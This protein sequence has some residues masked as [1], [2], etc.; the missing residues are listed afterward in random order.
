MCN[1]LLLS[2][3]SARAVVLLNIQICWITGQALST[4]WCCFVLG[5]LAICFSPSLIFVFDFQE[6]VHTSRICVGAAKAYWFYEHESAL[7]CCICLLQ[8][9]NLLFNWKE[10]GCWCLFEPDSFCLKWL[11]VLFWVVF[12]VL[13]FG[14]FYFSFALCPL[15]LERWCNVSR[16]NHVSWWHWWPWHSA[17]KS[18]RRKGR[19]RWQ[20]HWISS[21]SSWW[22]GSAGQAFLCTCS[23]GAKV[24]CPVVCKLYE[25]QKQ[26][27]CHWRSILY[28]SSDGCMTIK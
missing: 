8:C 13:L 10:W 19:A 20:Q 28:S 24:L 26:G 18:C 5:F 3:S 25:W 1:G 17:T 14:G 12:F 22:G 21:S 23:V 27:G 6:L 2:F 16:T 7:K 9:K 4:V 11:Q 15:P